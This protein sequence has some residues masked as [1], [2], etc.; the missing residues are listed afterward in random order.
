MYYSIISIMESKNNNR[1][2]DSEVD[3]EMEFIR[4]LKM[5]STAS[6]TSSLLAPKITQNSYTV[7]LLGPRFLSSSRFLLR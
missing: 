3:A 7:V 4:R 5:P 2:N 1:L 6:L